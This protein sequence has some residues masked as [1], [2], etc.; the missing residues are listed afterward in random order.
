MLNDTA[1][2]IA[3]FLDGR[4][5]RELLLMYCE[6]CDQYVYFPRLY[7]PNCFSDNLEWARAS[8]E[9]FVYSC[10]TIVHAGSGDRVLAIVELAEG[11]RMMSNIVGNGAASSAI[12]SSVHLE[13]VDDDSG[14]PLPVFRLES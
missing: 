13:F 6:P 2:V 9:G 8:G 5:N 12:G 3:T 11:P 14:V 10:T 7:C 1:S 4:R